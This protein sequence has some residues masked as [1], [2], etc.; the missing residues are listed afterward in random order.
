MYPIFITYICFKIE[1]GGT[2][3]C[4]TYEDA[5][6]VTLDLYNYFLRENK[7]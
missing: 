5:M 2:L 6:K 4:K 3:Q 7:S 1:L